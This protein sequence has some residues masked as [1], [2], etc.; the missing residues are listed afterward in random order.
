MHM[1]MREASTALTWRRLQQLQAYLGP[2]IS[3]V[4]IDSYF[5]HWPS[6]RK[7]RMTD[8]FYEHLDQTDMEYA[9]RTQFESQLQGEERTKEKLKA[10][11]TKLASSVADWAVKDEGDVT[12]IVPVIQT[13]V[14]EWKNMGLSALITDAAEQA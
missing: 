4:A 13:A 5:A 14:G 12:V 3:S 9:E 6:D 11:F 2:L 7:Q 8:Q 1:T 10:L